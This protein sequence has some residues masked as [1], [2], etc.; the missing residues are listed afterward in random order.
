MD[1]SQTNAARG[2]PPPEIA[3]MQL[4]EEGVRS[5]LEAIGRIA[6][7]GTQLGDAARGGNR[8]A[9]IA[10]QQTRMRARSEI[11]IASSPQNQPPVEW[12]MG[13]L[14]IEWSPDTNQLEW[15]ENTRPVVNI[16]PHSVE[17]TMKQYGSIKITVDEEKV[18][19]L[20]GKKVDV[21]L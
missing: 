12:D 1:T 8:V 16:T 20:S 9:E 19:Q 3:G 13:Y 7:T 17:I 5:T 14:N 11:N 21:K 6:S 2:A 18:V 4:R 10:Q 15:T